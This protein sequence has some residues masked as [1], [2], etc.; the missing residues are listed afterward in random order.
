M[1]D[2]IK[3]FTAASRTLRENGA[4]RVYIVATH[5]IF[6]GDSLQ[7]IQDEESIHEVRGAPPRRAA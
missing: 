6:S 2:G 7:Q 4:T 1:V 3:S 5:G